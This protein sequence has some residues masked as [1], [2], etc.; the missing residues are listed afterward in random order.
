MNCAEGVY[1]MPRTK[2]ALNEFI[3]EKKCAKCGKK[4]VPAV[5]HIYRKG[6][7]WYCSWTCY[8]HR[9]DEDKNSE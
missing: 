8:N 3:P 6:K 9:H 1:N 7:K 2:G 5:N 4:F